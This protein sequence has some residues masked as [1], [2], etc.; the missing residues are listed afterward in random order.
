MCCMKTC[1]P[2]NEWWFNNG[3]SW[4]KTNIGRTTA[5]N[6]VLTYTSCVYIMKSSETIFSVLLPVCQHISRRKNTTVISV[7]SLSNHYTQICNFVLLKLKC[8]NTM[9]TWQYFDCL[10]HNWWHKS[11]AFGWHLQSSKILT[12]QSFWASDR[13]SWVIHDVMLFVQRVLKN[14][15]TFI[16]M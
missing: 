12:F 3:W 15:H 4:S 5:S 11:L 2:N 9:T 6:I 16:Q 1:E 8:T 10:V 7:Q 13:I 14:T